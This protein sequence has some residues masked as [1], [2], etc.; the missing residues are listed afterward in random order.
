MLEDR[1]AVIISAVRTPLGSFMGGLSETGATDLGAMVIEE[2]IK[3]AGIA[4]DNIQEVMMG[5]VLPLGYGQ[6]PARQAAMK[7]GIPMDA[8]CVTMNKV[9]GSG[10]M[11]IMMAS[12]LIKSG[13]TDIAVAGGMENMSLAPFYIPKARKGT[14]MGNAEIKDHMVNDGLW[15]VVN[16]FHMGISNDLI[17][18]N[19]K[20]SREDQDRFAAES[21]ARTM[22]SIETGR[23]RD[24]IMP[25]PMKDRKGNPFYFDTD[26][27]PR[28]TSYE[29]LAKMKPAFQKEGFATAGNSSI[30]SDGASAVIIMSYAKAK[31][32]GLKPLVKVVASA[33]AGIELKY[34]LMAPINSI[35]KACK[36]AGIAIKDIGLHEINEAFSGSS[37]AVNRVLELDPAKVNVNG[38]G[39][40]LGHPIGASGSRVLTT[41]IYEMKRSGTALGQASLC[42]GGAEAVTMIVENV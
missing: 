14:R 34:V 32:M 22:K 13:Y 3:R 27:C 16:D 33:A 18:V 26:E 5:Q 19:W 28:H 40:A 39:V 35:P 24:E 7:A 23:F 9:C 2:A 36:K 11:T 25:V 8:G 1:D 21:Y 15:D 10:L 42:L 17:S 4:R 6:N 29:D 31:E 30:I 12:E 41:L 20:V 38:G 37:T